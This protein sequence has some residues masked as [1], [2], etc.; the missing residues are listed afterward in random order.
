MSDDAYFKLHK[1]KYANGRYIWNPN[2]DR[3]GYETFSGFRVYTTKNLDASTPATVPVL[4]DA[5]TITGRGRGKRVI[6]ALSSAM[7]TTV[8]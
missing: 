7:L 4:S 8:R 5:S 3:D 1:T 6:S 2:Y